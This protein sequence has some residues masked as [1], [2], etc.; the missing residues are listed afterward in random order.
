VIPP[1]LVAAA[2]ERVWQL[3]TFSKTLCPGLRVGWLAPPARA[4]ALELKRELD[5]LANGL[6]QA[7]LERFLDE[8]G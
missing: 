4:R 1:P 6:G 8:N 5:L 7:L 2:R 3:G